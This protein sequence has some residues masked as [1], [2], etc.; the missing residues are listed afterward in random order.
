MHQ[1]ELNRLPTYDDK[2][3]IAE[4]HRVADLLK[5]KALSR[6]QFDKHCKVSSSWLVRRFGSWEAALFK[7]GSMIRSIPL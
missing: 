7:L 5:S 3:V 1:F 2:T 4:I 6:R